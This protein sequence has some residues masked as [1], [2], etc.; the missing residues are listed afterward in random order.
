MGRVWAGGGGAGAGHRSPAE[1]PHPTPTRL[2]PRRLALGILMVPDG[3][4]LHGPCLLPESDPSPAGAGDEVPSLQ[5]CWGAS[6]APARRQYQSRSARPHLS[7]AAWHVGSF[8]KKNADLANMRSPGLGFSGVGMETR[9][10]SCPTQSSR[11]RPPHGGWGPWAEAESPTPPPF[12]K[13]TGRKWT[14][15]GPSSAWTCSSVEL[16]L[17]PGLS[18]TSWVQP[19][20]PSSPGLSRPGRQPPSPRL[21]GAPSATP[22]LGHLIPG[23]G[24]LCGSGC[25]GCSRALGPVPPAEEGE[26]PGPADAPEMG[27]LSHLPST[28]RVCPGHRD[29]TRATPRP[30][31]C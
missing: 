10:A 9:A 18:P 17:P 19:E 3:V 5:T 12:W 24:A 29:P 26:G 2:P 27:P 16:A 30:V 13:E 8:Q 1:P 6:H 7:R 20:T 25:P 11:D 15:P 31:S 4:S 22:D 14:C 21:K 23:A 28:A